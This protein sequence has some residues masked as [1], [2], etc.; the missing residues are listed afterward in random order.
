[1]SKSWQRHFYSLSGAGGAG[2]GRALGTGG[3]GAR[4]LV[5]DARGR[6]VD[7]SAS[8]VEHRMRKSAYL[9]ES[10]ERGVRVQCVVVAEA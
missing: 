1:M 9:E 6:S 5:G 3:G 8:G 2:T 10:G 4:S 7:Q